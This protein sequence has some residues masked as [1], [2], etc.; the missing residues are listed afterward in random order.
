MMTSPRLTPIRYSIQCCLG[1]DALRS[2]I[3]CWMT[4]PHRTASTGLSKIAIK[5][6]AGGFDEPSVVLC[7]AR[8]DK[9]ALDPLHATV[10]SFFIDFHQAAVAR[11]IASHYC[12]KTPR[13]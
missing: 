11:D 3:C 12:S 8:L 9:A 6:V 4:M 2:T 5:T 7:D 10:R 1:S 13:R